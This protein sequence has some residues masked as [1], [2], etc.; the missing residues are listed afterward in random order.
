MDEISKKIETGNLGQTLPTGVHK[1]GR[2]IQHAGGRMVIVGGCLRDLLLDRAIHD[3]DLATDLPPDQLRRAVPKSFDVGAR[4][5]TLLIPADGEI[6]E[7]TTFRRESD[8]SDFRHPDSVE[9]T[10]ELSEDLNRRDFT[11]NAMAWDPTAPQ[12]LI[13]PH[14]GR[15]DLSHRVIRAVGEPKDRIREDALRILRAVRFAVQL[16]FSIEPCTLNAMSES[17]ALVDHLS[18]ERIRDE[19][20]KILLSPKPSTGFLLLKQIDVLRRI[21][22]EIAECDGI[23]QNRFH[24]Y[25]VFEHTL[26]A[27]DAAAQDHLIVRLA[28]LFHDIGKPATR[29]VEEDVHFYGHQFVSAQKAGAIMNRLRY[30]NEERRKVKHLIRHHMFFFQTEWTDSAVRRFVRDVGMENIPDLFELRKAD[31]A[32]SGKRRANASRKLQELWDRI[33]EVLEKDNAF[34]VRDLA[35]DGN[36]IM[37]ELGVTPGRVIGDALHHLLELVLEDPELNTPESL[38]RELK[39]WYARNKHPE[40]TG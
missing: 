19:L 7:V 26:A 14:D 38:I 23:T 20:N 32:G 22:P 5:G 27:T 15:T 11:M 21:L 37:R 36:D 12:N 31:T 6:F 40:A 34:S 24:A 30:S 3:W 10:M 28:T 17:A 13:D 2:W 18:S 25:D 35:I 1:I 29:T 33:Q 4:F 9:F 39:E 8:Y 16:D